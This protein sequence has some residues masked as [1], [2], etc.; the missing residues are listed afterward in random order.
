MA[1]PLKDPSAEPFDQPY[2]VRLTK[3]QKLTQ[4]PELAKSHDMDESDFV[5]FRV[6]SAKPRRKKSTPERV[7]LITHL[8]QLGN[9]RA[10]INQLVKDRYK[11]VDAQ[12]LDRIFT[13]IETIAYKIHNELEQ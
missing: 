6:F 12:Q 11:H 3:T 4:L 8:G 1:R 2:L 10:D 7:S 13:A 5:R 9:I